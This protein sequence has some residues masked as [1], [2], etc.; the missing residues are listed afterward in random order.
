LT[1]QS[2]FQTGDATNLGQ[3]MSIRAG[4]LAALAGRVR[5]RLACIFGDEN[6]L[7][8]KSCAPGDLLAELDGKTVAIV[9]NSR[10]L[11]KTRF[12]AAIDANAIVI[13]INRAPM[14]D[15]VSHGAKTGWLALATSLDR[16]EE[17]RIC[18]DR[19]LWMSNK[20]KRLPFWVTGR[21][22]FYLHPQNEI[23][24]LGAQLGAPPTTGLMVIDL[25]MQSNAASV[26][27]YGFDFFASRSLTGRRN[28]AQV[29]HDFGAEKSWVSDLAKRDPRLTL[30]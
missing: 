2:G 5:F 26:A 6:L 24:A 27:L 29:P 11:A 18:P 1:R 23:Q 25:V 22:G 19:I 9:G 14:P 3:V 13:R 10:A 7:A 20:R 30:H 4:K 17:T 28:A 8:A 12:G 21:A 15:P 16:S